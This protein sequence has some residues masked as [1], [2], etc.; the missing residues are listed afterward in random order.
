MR[1]SWHLLISSLRASAKNSTWRSRDTVWHKSNK[2]AGRSHMIGVQ[3]ETGR[4]Q[5]ETQHRHCRNTVRA[6]WIQWKVQWV[7]VLA[8]V[9]P[10]GWGHGTGHSMAQEKSTQLL[11]IIQGQT[12]DVSEVRYKDITEVLKGCRYR[13][14]QLFKVTFHSL[15]ASTS[16]SCLFCR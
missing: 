13:S 16:V 14:H 10:S 12:V 9:S 3:N 15:L 6:D 2:D 11:A 1:A 8:P 5:A 4:S 7:H